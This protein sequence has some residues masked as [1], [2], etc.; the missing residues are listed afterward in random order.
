MSYIPVEYAKKIDDME[1]WKM[2]EKMVDGRFCGY[3]FD[4]VNN[5]TN[6]ILS[7]RFL[8]KDGIREYDEKV[9]V[10]LSFLENAKDISDKIN[11]EF[12]AAK[13][14]G[15]IRTELRDVLAHSLIVSEWAKNKQVFK[16]D[17]YFAQALIETKGLKL[18]RYQLE[19]LPCNCFY[20]DLSDIP[21]ANPIHGVFVRV[22]IEDN[23]CSIASYIILNDI[24]SPIF[25]SF[26][27]N[28]SFNNEDMINFENTINLAGS[29]DYSYTLS[30]F[31]SKKNFDFDF[32]G[33]YSRDDISRLMIQTICY[34]SSQ[35]PDVEV[36]PIT[37]TTYKPSKTVK[38]TFSEVRQYDVGVRY[39][40]VFSKQLKEAKR[41]LKQSNNIVSETKG[42][43]SPKP[44]F[45]SAH[46]SHFWTGKGRKNYEA[47]WIQAT[48]TG[49]KGNNIKENNTDV[50]IHKVKP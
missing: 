13:K 8:T 32:S 14:T 23:D 42:R 5:L 39:G 40:K 7:Q 36:S 34:L 1:Y 45:V 41:Q 2:V 4:D 31:D 24:T 20:L 49:F 37:K 28:N 30:F 29:A 35:E 38:N 17:K 12:I 16:L 46:W 22:H 50:V 19:H 26:Y 9:I 6:Y 27:S 43:K 18:S 15:I 11:K 33:T 47:R 44:H 10:L 3:K 25:Y 48:F 21:Q